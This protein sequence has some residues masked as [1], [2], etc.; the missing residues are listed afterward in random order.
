[1]VK[2]KSSYAKRDG[3]REEE[4]KKEGKKE[5]LRGSRGRRLEISRTRA[6]STKGKIMS[7]SEITR[8]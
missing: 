8:Q 3:R 2:E 6:I 7:R 1:M 5:Q 4:K